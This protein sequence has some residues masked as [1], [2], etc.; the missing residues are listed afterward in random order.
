MSGMPR[1]RLALLLALTFTLVLGSCGQSD[2]KEAAK[3][4][5]PQKKEM[6]K[7]P[8]RLN[9]VRDAMGK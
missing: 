8:S 1:S 4:P 3:S 2:N 6:N 5:P 9:A 7:D